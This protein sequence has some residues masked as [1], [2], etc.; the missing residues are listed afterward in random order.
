MSSSVADKP[1]TAHFSFAISLMSSIA[2]RVSSA[3]IPVLKVTRIGVLPS[4]LI[5]PLTSSGRESRGT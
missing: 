3:A 1:A 4:A 5:F 2:L